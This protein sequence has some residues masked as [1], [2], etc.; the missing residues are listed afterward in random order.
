MAYV[1]L[2]IFVVL[3]IWIYLSKGKKLQATH[4][5]NCGVKLKGGEVI[6][7]SCGFHIMSKFNYCQQ[8]GVKTQQGQVMCPSCSFKLRDLYGDSDRF[9]HDNGF[10]ILGLLLPI[11]GFVIYLAWYETRPAKA[12]SAGLGA[13]IGFV[14]IILISIVSIISM[15]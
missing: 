5:R 1:L 14:A 8:C 9:K 13:L 3:L 12:R 2:I 11:I 6:C 7:L 15:Y 10:A 4:C